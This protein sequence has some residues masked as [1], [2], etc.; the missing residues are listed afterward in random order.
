LPCRSLASD[1]AREKKWADEV[2]PA[3]LTGD[4]VWLELSGGHKFLTLY[5]EARQCQGGRHRGARHGRAPGL[6][7]DR[8]LRQRLPDQ[9]YATLSVQ[10]PV[11]KA[12]AK[13]EAY[14]PT[15]DEAAER[16]KTGARFHEGQG[17]QENRGQPQHGLPHDRALRRGI[18]MRTGRLGGDRRAGRD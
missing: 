17:L 4:P 1:Y 13:G 3:V 16:I 18:R 6:G 14:P 10:M 5:T 2:L 12:D 9:G 8:P 7:P 11:L 15:F